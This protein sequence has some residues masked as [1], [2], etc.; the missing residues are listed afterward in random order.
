MPLPVYLLAHPGARLSDG[1]RA[2]LRAWTAPARR[3]GTDRGSGHGRDA[4]RDHDHR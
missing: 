1:D 4:D 3:G 2:A